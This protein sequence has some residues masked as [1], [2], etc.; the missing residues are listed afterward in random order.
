[1][2]VANAAGGGYLV[3]TSTGGSFIE[4]LRNRTVAFRLG[5]QRLPG[6][7]ENLTIPKQSGTATAQFMPTEGT[8][9]TE[10]QQT[11]TQVT[12]MPKLCIAHTEVSAKLLL[13]SNPA[14]EG[15]VTD[16]LAGVLGVAADDTILNG[17]GTAG[18]PTGIRFTSGVGSFSGT[19]LGLTGLMD[20]QEDVL[21]ANAMLNPATL[22][23]AAAV[24]VAKLLKG[25][26]RF[27]G[28]DTPMWQGPLHDGAVEGVRAIS[29]Q[30]VPAATMIYG[31]WSQILVPEWGALAVGI[32]PFA[33]FPAGIVGIRA[34]WAMDVIV[35][36]AA[37]FTVATSVT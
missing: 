17:N 12:A 29:S 3:G 24:G 8:A 25:R 11:F 19:T 14:A 35:R 27:T 23:Y 16:D 20:A 33:N 6:Q 22:G 1:L 21:M 9:A 28:T 2:T 10:S 30:Q 18:T 7:R 31:D 4:A 5:A 26:Q 13:Q 32:N 34:M 15:I 36:H 37:S